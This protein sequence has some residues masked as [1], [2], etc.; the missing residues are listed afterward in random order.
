[1]RLAFQRWL[2]ESTPDTLV[3]IEITPQPPGSLLSGDKPL[4]RDHLAELLGSQSKFSP[5][6]QLEIPEL[7]DRAMIWRKAESSDGKD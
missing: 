7:G 1:M 6:R 3:V 5:Q 4:V 2:T